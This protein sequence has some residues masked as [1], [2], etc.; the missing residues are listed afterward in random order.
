MNK[1]QR[2][3][4]EQLIDDYGFVER[5]YEDCKWAEKVIEYDNCKLD[6]TFTFDKPSFIVSIVL[7]EV[8]FSDV[9]I[10]RTPATKS[11]WCEIQSLIRVL[12]SYSNIHE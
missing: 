5:E 8:G 1:A 12:N 2:K 11:D 6:I 4:L 9:E 3:L 10:M 7:N